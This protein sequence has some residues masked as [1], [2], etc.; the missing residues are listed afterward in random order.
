MVLNANDLRGLPV[1]APL[2]AAVI[3][4]FCTLFDIPALTEKWFVENGVNLPDPAP[5]L[6]LS[7]GL[8]DRDNFVHGLLDCQVYYCP[9]QHTHFWISDEKRAGRQLR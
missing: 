8:E 9:C 1:Y 6:I 2:L 3:A 7:A 4:P 5:N